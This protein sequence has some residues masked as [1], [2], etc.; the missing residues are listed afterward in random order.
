GNFSTLA[1]RPEFAEQRVVICHQRLRTY[2]TARNEAPQILAARSQVLNFPAFVWRA[3]KGGFRQLLVIDG[4][5]KPRTEFPQ[6][7][8]V[9]FFLLVS[10]VPAFAALAQAVALN[11]PRQD[12]RG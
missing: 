7:F 2:F 9:Q 6:L 5:A 11:C 4:N 12:Y 10:D 8:F 3:I 1:A